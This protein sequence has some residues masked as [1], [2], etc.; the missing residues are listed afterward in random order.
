[1]NIQCSTFTALSLLLFHC[2][3][4]IVSLFSCFAAT[5]APLI[6]F[7]L[8]WLR[9][10]GHYVSVSEWWCQI[11]VI[12]FPVCTFLSLQI[13]WVLFCLSPIKQLLVGASVLVVYVSSEESGLKP[14]RTDTGCCQELAAHKHRFTTLIPPSL[15]FFTYILIT[16][17][18][19]WQATNTTSTKANNTSI[20]LNNW[21]ILPLYKKAKESS[22]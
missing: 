15:F 3:T 14:Q 10:P 13:V 7:F 4:S 21:R 19:E 5:S 12:V 8:G 18:Q 1:M 2:L 16:H 22:I 17:C 11:L 9:V 6:F 20:L